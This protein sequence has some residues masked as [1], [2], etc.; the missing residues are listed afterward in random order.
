MLLFRKL[1]FILSN[2]KKTSQDKMK[3]FSRDRLA[4]TITLFQLYIVE[5]KIN[6][7]NYKVA[8]LIK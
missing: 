7:K 2:T 4:A 5:G 8:L 3:H 6:S 1:E